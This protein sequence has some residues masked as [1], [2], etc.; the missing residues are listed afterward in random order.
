[1]K[2]KL[3]L[4]LALA[5]AGLAGL[6]FTILRSGDGDV[7]LAGPALAGPAAQDD[8]P[9][10]PEL[11]V[12]TGDEAR[13]LTAFDAA[14]GSAEAMAAQLLA[15]GAV[16]GGVTGRLVDAAGK[17]VAGEPVWLATG[18]DRWEPERD[19]RLP[20]LAAR[21]VS[22]ADGAFQLAARAGV[23]YDL[24]AGGSRWPATS[25]QDVHAGDA[26]VVVMPPP[27]VLTG[28]VVDDKSGQGVDGAHLL[29]AQGAASLLA[30]AR[31]DGTFEITPLP[32]EDVIVIAWAPGFDVAISPNVAPGQ[33]SLTMQLGPARTV[34][35]RL[36]D[37]S[38]Q[39]PLA[40][41]KVQLVIRTE[42]MIAGGEPVP[43]SKL[44]AEM[45]A[46]VDTS[47][48]F[49]IEG[50][51][52]SGW[53]LLC[54][55][56]GYLPEKF[57][58][59][60]DRMLDP[61]DEVVVPLR[62][63]DDLAGR[64]IIASTGAPAEGADVSMTVPDGEVAHAAV[65]GQGDF[66][67][68]PAG[69]PVEKLAQRPLVVTAHAPG[70]AARVR[71]GGRNND[72]LLL[73]LVPVL[74][75]AV[76]VLDGGK[77]AVGAEVA[78]RSQG[79]ETTQGVSDANG[80]VS[81]VHEVAGPDVDRVTVQARRGDVESLP[82]IV[83]PKNP[84]EGTITVDLQAGAWLT[85]AITDLGGQPIASALISARPVDRNSTDPRRSGRTD[86]K[87][88]FRVGPLPAQVEYRVRVS[89]DGFLDSDN[90]GIFAGAG[91]MNV[92]LAPVVRWQGSALAAAGGPARR[93]FWGQLVQ[94]TRDDKGNVRERNTNERIHFLPDV[95]GGFA[96]DLPGP[97][98]YVLRLN[99]QDS[100]PASSDPFDFDGVR[101]PPF[102]SLVLPS[103]AMLEVTVLDGRGRPVPGYAVA[104]A[105]WEIAEKAQAPTGD[106][107]KKSVSGRTD[108]N[109]LARL[110]L[111]AGGAYRI[112][113]GPGLWFDD[114]SINVL[115]GVPVA[116]IYHLPPTGDIEV[117]LRDD[118]GEPILG[119][120]VEVR[121]NKDEKVHSVTRRMRT[122]Q[123][124]DGTVLIE[125]LPPGE[126]DVSA[127]RRGFDNGTQTVHV[128]DGVQHI[129]MVLVTHPPDQ[130]GNNGPGGGG[131]GGGG[132][133]GGWNGGGGG[134]GFGG[135]GLGG[136]NAAQGGPH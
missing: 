119:A 12:A 25:R 134:Q 9:V 50:A 35:G 56:D 89:A 20:R 36:V 80:N 102:T 57:D 7:S 15:L 116:R 32:P 97:G 23:N 48:R 55:S 94:Q 33:G 132:G 42:A 73:Q 75:L 61:N 13:G 126:Y 76:Q 123:D 69:L 120:M 111:G 47:G 101:A 71:P 82:V 108:D 122:S 10:A 121:S 109:G 88:H 77:P 3:S 106:V 135:Q 27:A 6:I 26:L 22:G 40:G 34:K 92:S 18:D 38:T 98:R 2:R 74:P 100:V 28:I 16:R 11:P 79:A 125:T 113:G 8:T 1:M 52:S 44:I 131:P 67:L 5:L 41:G 45:D 4:A 95:A 128:S 29:I 104:A 99:A 83:D 39:K 17:A 124:S 117:A 96:F 136:Q 115:P 24:Q 51:P 63:I 19:S 59:Y 46:D 91:D 105:P 66:A 60:R 64:A 70:L 58:R 110:N 93:D 43:V 118:K 21:A 37:R 54:S 129:T 130:P 112:A 31:P 65:S 53:E 127:R 103:A 62:G 114:G 68:K 90:K 86:D 72:E 87:G 107:R 30:D 84:P 49:I 14:P 133:G 81:L 78:A 85:G